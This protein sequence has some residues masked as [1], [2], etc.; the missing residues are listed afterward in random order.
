MIFVVILGELT[1]FYRKET[2]YMNDEGLARAYLNKS[3]S[4][5]DRG[6]Q[7]TLSL[8]SFANLMRSKKCAYTGILLTDPVKGKKGKGVVSRG[9]DRTIE[10]LDNTKGYEKGN[11]IAVC[12]AANTLKNLVCEIPNRSMEIYHFIKMAKIIEKKLKITKKRK[13]KKKK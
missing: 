6:I 3:R 2:G 1:R 7:F 9:T 13:L 11:V 5:K 4:S 12:Y 8:L 10:R